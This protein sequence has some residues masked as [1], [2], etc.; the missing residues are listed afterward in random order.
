MDRRHF[1][2]SLAGPALAASTSQAQTSAA[3]RQ[4]NVLFIL[5]DKCRR[6]AFGAYG[7]RKVHTPNIDW[8]AETGTRFANCYT[9]QALC[10]PARAS[11]LT[12]AFPHAHGVQRNVY[13]VA[14]PDYS[15]NPSRFDEAVPDPFRDPRFR[16]AHNW[17]YYLN[18]AGY[19]TAQ[20]GKWHLGPNNPGFFDYF[21]GFNSLLHH[22]TGKPH[23]SPYRPDVHTGLGAGFIDKHAGSPFFLQ[24][25]YYP[26]HGPDDPPKEYL[27]YY[28]GEEHPEYYAA[29][30]NLDWNVGRLLDALRRNKILD[31]TLIIVT[32]E[33]G[34]TWTN[35]PGSTEGMCV[36]Y[37]E[38]AR[39]PLI[40]RY[41]KLFPQGKV[42]N[43]GVSLV[44]L[45]PTILEATDVTPASAAKMQGRSLIGLVRSGQDRWDR[46]IV[47]ENVPQRA[48]DDS[49][50]EERA[51]RDE[52]YKLILR[53]YAVRP[54]FRPGELYDLRND[55]GEGNNVYSSN[56][57]VVRHLAESLMAWGQENEDPRSIQLAAWVLDQ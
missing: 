46:P 7:V 4:P 37:E 51:I 44:D 15:L 19:Y 52:R 21:K 39:I 36:A 13:P 32:T 26:P 45:M 18:A 14:S 43:S 24:Q 1:F 40:I 5:F 48:I 28:E 34:R 55:S 38:S 12:G 9:P 20:I 49:F 2:A 54:N 41:P 33:H 22:W 47:I 29:V 3:Q 56:P 53:N 8:L 42:W 57:Q 10:S 25:S 27:K 30:S 31:E 50:Y 17:A 35:R 11:I 16:L 6:D 23:E